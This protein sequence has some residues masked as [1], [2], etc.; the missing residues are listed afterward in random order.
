MVA[1]ALEK[2]FGWQVGDGRSIQIDRDTWGFKGLND[3]AL[4]LLYEA[5]QEMHVRDLWG[6]LGELYL[7]GY[8]PHRFF[9]KFIWKLKI[10]PKIW[11]FTWCFGHSFL[12]TNTKFLS[13]KSHVDPV[14]SRCRNGDETLLHALKYCPKAC[15]VLIADGFD[16]QLLT[17]SYDFCID[18]IEESMRILD[19]KAFEYFISTL[20]I[21]WN[22]RNNA[23]FMR[24]CSSKKPPKGVINVNI[25]AVVNSCGTSLGIIARDSDVFVLS[26]RASFTNK[27]INPEWAKLDASIMAFDLLIFS[28]LIR[29]FFNR[30]VQAQSTALVTT[31]K[32]SRSLGVGSKKLISFLT[33]LY[34]PRSNGL[35]GIVTNYPILFVIGLI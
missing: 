20:W 2:G 18:W 21:I 13:I 5:L 23:V 1:K 12:P 24:Y 14:C 31:R 33:L 3:K 6:L 28:M 15:D 32:T 29:S 25:N 17:N 16:N 9:W 34:S 26:G 35:T 22:S 30:I 19:K 11:V 8:G 27:V 4:Q 7:V 10:L